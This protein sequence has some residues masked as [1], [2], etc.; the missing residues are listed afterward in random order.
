MLLKFINSN[1]AGL[2]MLILILAILL[3]LHTLIEPVIPAS[4]D[5]A[6]AGPLGRLLLDPLSARP[7]LS[8]LI[9]MIIV[10][11]YGL[12]LNQLN[13]EYAL[14]KTRSQL[15]QL[16]FI[17]VAGTLLPLHFL[18]P[19]LMASFFVILLI[20]RLFKSYKKDRLI[21][22]FLDA[23]ILLAIAV[24]IYI[25]FVILLPLFFITLV[26]FRNTVWQEWTYPW[27]GFC[28]PFLFWGTYL[29]MTEQPLSLMMHEFHRVFA[30]PGTNPDYPLMQLVF[31][32]YL[33]LLVLIGSIFMIRTIGI[34]NIQSR[35]FFIFF[36]WLFI[37][38]I[39]TV[40]LIPSVKHEMIYVGGISVAI[41]LSN[42]FASCSNTR[43]NNLLLLL[44]AAGI[45]L[46][47]IH[48]WFDLF[49]ASL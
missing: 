31:Y 34:R 11:F 37:L 38:S 39:I 32:A 33:A 19:A 17:L 28:I 29:F 49:P 16:F 23:G 48:E 40:L 21:F 18:S 47:I 15:P 8:A 26:L 14:L 42:Y 27:I 41:L 12:L 9:A 22:N 4:W 44:L 25:P 30:V 46:I 35:A 2:Q 3:W 24:I 13:N 6:L 5:N 43:M 10:I 20:Y 36:L 1:K 45:I 7:G